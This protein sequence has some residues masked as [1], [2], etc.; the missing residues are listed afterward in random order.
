MAA[1]DSGDTTG[2]RGLASLLDLSYVD[3]PD[4]RTY[5]L[6]VGALPEIGLLADNAHSVSDLMYGRYR[7]C[8]LQA[9]DLTLP[10]YADDPS[11]PERSCALVTFVAGFPH[12]EL[13]SHTP[14]S[15][16][17]IS[18]QRD[19]LDF[20]P[21]GFRDRFDVATDDNETA[22]A[23][24]SDEMVNWLAEGRDDVRV[25]LSGGSLLGHVPQL[26]PD[27]HEAWESLIDYIVDFHAHIPEQAWIDYN[28]FWLT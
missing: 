17:R 26:G 10:T 21:D 14:M 15:R 22:R 18:R 16:M 2:M 27:D 6:E 13:T 4:D 8:N 9:F 24:L 20:V 23:L 7:G 3:T 28:T 19:W 25:E 5:H 1:W 11:A 12:L